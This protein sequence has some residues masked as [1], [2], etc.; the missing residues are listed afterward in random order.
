MSSLPSI[1]PAQAEENHS[2]KKISK[3]KYCN[4]PDSVRRSF[5][6]RVDSHEVTIKEVK[7]FY[8]LKKKKMAIK[9]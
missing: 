3:K 2:T 9:K 4:I 8:I 7:H 1:C 5:I 6:K